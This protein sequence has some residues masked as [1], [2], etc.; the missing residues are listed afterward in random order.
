MPSAVLF[1]P[2]QL[3]A[4]ERARPGPLDRIAHH[5]DLRTLFG[6]VLHGGIQNAVDVAVLRQI[7]IAITSSPTPSR[8]SCYMTGLPVPDAPITAMESRVRRDWAGLA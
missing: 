2:E 1:R 6:G 5:V 8:I 3:Q 4:P 7:V